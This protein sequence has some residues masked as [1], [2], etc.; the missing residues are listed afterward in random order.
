MYEERDSPQE[1]NISTERD[2]LNPPYPEK[3]QIKQDEINKENNNIKNNQQKDELKQLSISS[4]KELIKKLLQN[5]LNNS[6]LKL[7]TNSTNHISTLEKA[8]ESFKNF[9]NLIN[10][11][12]KKVEEAKKKKEK[13]KEKEKK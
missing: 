1:Q 9:T 8:T 13:E 4:T 12:T 7:E 2:L 10:N 11:L 6:I 5:T 3:E